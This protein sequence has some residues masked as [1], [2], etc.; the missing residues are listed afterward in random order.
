MW[1]QSTRVKVRNLIYSSRLYMFEKVILHSYN[2]G[3]VRMIIP[4][5]SLACLTSLIFSFN[6]FFA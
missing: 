5:H 1:M 6:L 2:I 3:D 4:V